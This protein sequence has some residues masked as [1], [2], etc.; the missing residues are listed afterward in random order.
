MLRMVSVTHGSSMTVRTGKI[1][2]T[3]ASPGTKASSLKSAPFRT[4]LREPVLAPPLH[5]TI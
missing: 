4:T 2:A 3:S 1:L 5:V